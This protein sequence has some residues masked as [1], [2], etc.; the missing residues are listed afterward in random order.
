MK[1]ILLPELAESVVEGEILKWLVEEGDTIALEQ[2]LC[3]VMTDKVTVELPSPAAGILSKR[4]AQEGDVVAVHAVIALIDESGQAGAAAPA[5]QPSPTQA[6]QDSGENPG[7]ADAQLPPQAQEERE[8]VAQEEQGGSIVEAGHMKG[9]ADDD[10]SSLFKAFASDEQVKVQGLGSRS[11][12]SAPGSSTAGTGMLNREPAPAT[13]ADGRVLAVPA[14]RQLAREL[15]ID[16]AQ[17]QG[18]G[19]NGRIRVQDVTAHGQG[20]GEQASAPQQ[21]AP[22]QTQAQAPQTQSAPSQPAAK[23]AGS[24]PVAPVQYR[25]PKGYEHLEDR[26]PLRGMRRA[27]SNQMQASH[28]YTVRTLTVDEVNL[29]KLVEFRGRVKDEARAAGVK[30]SYLP[31]IFKAVTAAL[32]KYPSLNT[33]FDE[34]SGEIV[35]KRYYHM[36]MAVATDAGLTVPVLKDVNQ[37]SIFELANEVVDL[38]GRAQAG[39]LAPDELAGSTFSITNIGSI[40]ALFSFPIINVPDAAILG[41]HSIVKRPIVDE[42]DNI[43]VAHM[44]YL[45]LSFDHRLVDGAEAARFCKEVIRLLENPDRL[46]LEAM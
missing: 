12:S 28:L 10:S 21:Q 22:T 46:M 30:L 23:G 6:I 15:G 9:G 43:V 39:K 19:P 20:G 36:G 45:S 5:A 13:R 38:A 14:A 29:T 11:G 33:S 24:M 7:T 35:Q 1:E 27:I 4:M 16:L 37:K 25:T 18:S 42:H 31:F 34:A 3:E 17:V 32:K 40:G 44:M 26:V 8:Q 41:I 2:P